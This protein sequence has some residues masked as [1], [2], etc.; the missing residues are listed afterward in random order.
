M[1]LGMQLNARLEQNLSVQMLQSVNILQMTTQELDLAVK[2]EVEENPLLE[3]SEEENFSDEDWNEKEGDKKLVQDDSDESESGMRETKSKELDWEEYFKDGFAHSETA[4]EDFSLANFE[5]KEWKRE[6][7]SSESLQDK[8]LL[9]LRDWNRPPKIKMLVE[10]L[11]NSLD[12]RGYLVASSI[13]FPEGSAIENDSD[14]VEIQEVI[15][16]VRALE[17]A[18]LDVQ[19]AFHVLH[20]MTPRGIGARTLRE[21]LLI[22]AY[23]LPDFSPLAISILENHFEELKALRYSSIAKALNL[24]LE[25]ILSAI[26]ALSVLSPHPGLLLSD[27]PVACVTPDLEVIEILPGKFRAAL[28]RESGFRHRLRINRTYEKLLNNPKTSK[29]DKEYIRERLNKANMF[30]F[31]IGN[32]ESTIVRVMQKIIDLQPEFF[33][34]GKEH[35]RPMILQEVADAL[36]LNLSTIS[37]TVN[38]KYVET[39]YGVFELRHFFGTAVKQEDG[40]DLS[41]KKIIS[42]IKE[43]IDSEDKS[44]PLSDQALTDALAQKNIK[45]ARR[46]VAKYREEVLKILPAKFRKSK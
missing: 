30:L 24:N 14:L 41:T 5:E 27:S 32:R 19:E 43:L 35:L 31:T 25:E 2:E 6:T 20:S 40:S 42:E 4:R 46:T 10:Y 29:E 18:S 44:K 3:F 1:D 33:S 37:R 13:D 21:C 28:K 26:Q 34:R 17:R 45:V 9:Q 12:E 8:L 36:Q 7:K 22:Q 15:D 11:I 39:K 23:A 38:G 16:G